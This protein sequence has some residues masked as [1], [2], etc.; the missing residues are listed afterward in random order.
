VQKVEADTE[1]LRKKARDDKI[2]RILEGS[3]VCV[4]FKVGNCAHSAVSER[5][6]AEAEAES[7]T[8]DPHAAAH[9]A[10]QAQQQQQQQPTEHRILG[11]NDVLSG[12]RVVA[13]C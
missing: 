13:C 7:K 6:K 5:R 10:Q 2:T 1:A 11:E 4:H 9:A 3:A 12:H 8:A